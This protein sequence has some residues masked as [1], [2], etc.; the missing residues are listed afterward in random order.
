M[1]ADTLQSKGDYDLAISQYEKGFSEYKNALDQSDPEPMQPT[2]YQEALA[3]GNYFVCLWMNPARRYGRETIAAAE[4]AFTVVEAVSNTPENDAFIERQCISLALYLAWP[5]DGEMPDDG[6]ARLKLLDKADKFCDAALVLFPSDK[7]TLEYLSAN[8]K[9]IRAAVLLRRGAFSDCIQLLQT[10]LPTLKATFNHARRDILVVKA[11]EKAT[12][13]YANAQ[14]S[15]ICFDYLAAL[16]ELA[17][18]HERAG[19]WR[20]A[21]T[22]AALAMAHVQEL[23]STPFFAKYEQVELKEMMDRLARVIA[24]SFMYGSLFRRS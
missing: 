23:Q 9:R 22:I 20:E 24:N 1:A 12:T 13:Q 17:A 19:N 2:K 21:I 6:G 3:L 8:I 4:K 11:N 7:E 15:L 14:N 5:G 10:A 18:A 16:A